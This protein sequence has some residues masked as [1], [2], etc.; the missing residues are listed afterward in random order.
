MKTIISAYAPQIFGLILTAIAG[1]L[2]IVVRKL[3]TKYIN[4]EIK[5]KLAKTTVQA[6]EQMYK[7]I[8]G[9]EKLGKAMEY[10]S[11]V[12]ESHGIKITTTEMKLLLE[13]AVG[14]FNKV[15]DKEA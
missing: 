1:A 9:D 8:H 10:L 11:T 6:I 2:G 4:T 14:E 3:A 15:F 7:D 5:E 13:S 12:L